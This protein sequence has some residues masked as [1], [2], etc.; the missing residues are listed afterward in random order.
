M[1]LGHV[2]Q[3]RAVAVAPPEREIVHAEHRHRT[4]RRIRRAADQAQQAATRHGHA[5]PGRQPRPGTASQGERNR[6]Q[7]TGQQHGPPGVADGQIGDLLG[8]GS[9]LARRV[10][11]EETAYIKANCHRPAA[12]HRVRQGALIS[13]VHP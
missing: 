13:A 10:V 2:H 7:H 8:E 3:D 4:D 1:A 5:H 11:A 6:S 12:G 9:R